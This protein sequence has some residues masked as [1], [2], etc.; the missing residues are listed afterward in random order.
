MNRRP[1]HAARGRDVITRIRPAFR[2]ANARSIRS[3]VPAGKGNDT[4][5]MAHQQGPHDCGDR[6]TTGECRRASHTTTV[7]LHLTKT[8]GRTRWGCRVAIGWSAPRRA[9]APRC[10]CAL[11]RGIE[12]PPPCAPSVVNGR[13]HDA[14]QATQDDERRR[15]VSASEM[16]WRRRSQGRSRAR[17]CRGDGDVVGQLARELEAR[18]LGRTRNVVP[19]GKGAPMS[20]MSP[21][22]SPST[23]SPSSPSARREYD[24]TQFMD[25]LLIAVRQPANNAWAS[26]PLHRACAL[27]MPGTRRRARASSRRSRSRSSTCS[28]A[29]STTRTR[30]R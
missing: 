21:Q 30:L 2:S 9:P 1:P 25:A 22:A 26:F 4:T 10:P 16:S 28:S 5:A 3:T 12:H 24:L 7:P 20:R 8:T 29:R 13:A 6:S 27:R 14:D 17:H 15:E 11:R 18:R 19:L 23:W